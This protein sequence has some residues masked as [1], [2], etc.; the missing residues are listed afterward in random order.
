MVIRWQTCFSTSSFYIVVFLFLLPSVVESTRPELI[1]PCYAGNHDCDTTAQCIPLE[2][3]DFQ[4]QCATGY[5]GD[6]H[7]C[8]GTES[9]WI[10]LD[11]WYLACFDGLCPKALLG[12][13][14]TSLVILPPPL[15]DKIKDSWRRCICAPSPSSYLLLIS[16]L[17]PTVNSTLNKDLQS[18]KL[19]PGLSLAQQQVCLSC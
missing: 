16:S 11:I 6:G 5:R 12:V 4:C 2:G 18:F 14:R 10:I 17:P 7:N 3:Q 9:C 1:N 19:M 13:V 15:R 8:Y